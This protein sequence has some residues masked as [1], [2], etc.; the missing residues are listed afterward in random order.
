MSK[1]DQKFMREALRQAKK[2]MGRTSPNPV[3]GAVI[4]RNGEIIASGFHRKA[5]EKHAEIA[6]LEKIGGKARNGDSLYVTLEP[7]NHYGRTPPCTGAILKSGIKR[8]V[9]GMR[10]PNPKVSGGGCEFLEQRGVKVII[11]I[12]ETEC[13]RMN[14]AFVKHVSEGRPF[15][16][17]KSALTMDGWTATSM[18]HSQWVTNEKSRQFVHRM[19]DRVDGIMVG[20]GTVLAD[21]P[22]LTTRLKNRQGKDPIRII[23][24]TRLRIPHNARILNNESPSITMV[25]VGRDVPRARLEKIQRDGVSTVRCLEKDGRIELSVLMD[26]LGERSIT[27]LLVEGGSVLIGS[28]I[29]ERLIDKFYIFKAPKIFG[30]NDG[31]PMAT[32]P[33]PKR[34]DEC[35]MLKDIKVRRFGDDILIR[36]YPVKDN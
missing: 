23:V 35:L 2:G 29:R 12:L 1:T 18:K 27:S 4:V 20:I 21:D 24:D 15:V 6:V 13:R 25:V 3:V 16:I 19:R 14:E 33:G 32:G 10:D 8:V 9:V 22:L 36:G 28:M 7:C 26:I 30:G 31:I 11:G 34:M 5:G 17:A